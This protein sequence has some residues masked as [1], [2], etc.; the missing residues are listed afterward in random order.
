MASLLVPLAIAAFGIYVH[1][2]TK[3]FEH[4]QWRS[5]KLVE[6]RLSIY[7]DLAP[8]LNDVLCYFTYVGGWR[9]MN[10]PDVIGLKRKIDKKVHLAAP[11]YT[12]VFYETCMHFQNTCFETYGGW[13]KDAKLRTQFQRRKESRSD[14]KPEWDEHFSTAHMPPQAVREAYDA[15][16]TVMAQD[17]G[18]N[19]AIV[20]PPS[21]PP[22]LNRR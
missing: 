21:G 13:G 15:I 20:V 6:K 4:V 8:M 7:D 22:P 3:R 12:R 11:L 19:E 10:P 9:D 17:I 1:R 16:M 18:V 14:W 5:Q 2:I